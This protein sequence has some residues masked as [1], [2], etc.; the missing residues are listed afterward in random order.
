MRMSAAPMMLT[1]CTRKA[2]VT[3]VMVTRGVPLD[4]VLLEA[5]VAWRGEAE[6]N[7]CVTIVTKLG[8]WLA[9]VGTPLRR[10]G[11]AAS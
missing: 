4:E 1:G 8:I 9:T 10:V 11:I 6:T 5:V 7:S 3:I 2:Q